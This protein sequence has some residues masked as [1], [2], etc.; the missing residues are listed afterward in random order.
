M[1][2]STYKLEW[3]AQNKVQITQFGEQIK[4][5]FGRMWGKEG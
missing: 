3:N 5:I 4:G 1:L 2:K